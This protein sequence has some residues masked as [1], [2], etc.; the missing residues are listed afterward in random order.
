M[1]SLAYNDLFGLQST[2]VT[3][4]KQKNVPLFKDNK[5]Q[6]QLDSKF[7]II[8]TFHGDGGIH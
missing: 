7:K 2:Q 8:D 1:D 3:V 6:V 5:C 4:L